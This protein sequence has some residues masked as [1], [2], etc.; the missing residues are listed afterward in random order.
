METVKGSLVT[1]KRLSEREQMILEACK[2][3]R[4]RKMLVGGIAWCTVAGK[5]R[6]LRNAGRA[7]NADGSSNSM[8][9][10]GSW[11]K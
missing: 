9:Q 6:A 7:S 5:L 1:F 11:H 10:Q 4:G 8:E 3:V 2:L